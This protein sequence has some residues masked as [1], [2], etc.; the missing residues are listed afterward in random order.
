LAAAFIQDWT[1]TGRPLYDDRDR[2]PDQPQPGV[3]AVQVLR[4]S[5]S[6]GWN[7]IRTVWYV[8]IRSAQHRIRLQTAYFSPDSHLVA[9]LKEAVS[10]GVHAPPPLSAQVTSTEDRSTMTKRSPW[11]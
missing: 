5:A 2:F 8:L 3:A 10:R 11:W 7:D 6:I 9:A 4:G 1:E